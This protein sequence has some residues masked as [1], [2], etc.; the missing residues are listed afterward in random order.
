MKYMT[1]TIP[2]QL[3]QLCQ[4]WRTRVETVASHLT[5][6]FAIERIREGRSRIEREMSGKILTISVKDLLRRNSSRISLYIACHGS[7]SGRKRF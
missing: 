3:R 7:V 6:R 1:E 2:F 5:E 4:R